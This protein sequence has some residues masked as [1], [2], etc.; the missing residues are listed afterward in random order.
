MTARTRS[1]PCLTI[2]AALSQSG[3]ND[4]TFVADGTYNE[5]VTLSDEKSLV[6]LDSTDP[7]P[8]IDNGSLPGAAVKVDS[9]DTAAAVSGFTIRSESQ[10]MDVGGGVDIHDNVF[11]ALNPSDG[12]DIRLGTAGSVTIHDNVF[13][14]PDA[15]GAQ[16][17]IKIEG[18]PSPVISGNTFTD[19]SAGVIAI[20]GDPRIS[21]SQFS[22]ARPLPPDPGIGDIP[23]ADVIV[24]G[25]TPTIVGNTF[26]APAQGPSAGVFVENLP[27]P[28][29]D[30]TGA[31]LSRNRISGMDVGVQVVDTD[32]PVTLSND[33]I[34][35]NTTGL[36]STDTSGDSPPSTQDQRR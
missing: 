14:D 26:G 35:G 5:S 16:I 23:A 15:S 31:T 30:S 8:I 2:A 28:G 21:N 13:V 12:F 29:A 34:Y 32:L 27:F 18:A 25:G 7:K 33:L 4:T 11:D 10:P 20:S 9:S 22:G 19:L 24:V 3:A 36:E 1:T 17:G 6:S